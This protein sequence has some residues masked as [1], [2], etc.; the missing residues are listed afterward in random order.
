MPVFFYFLS[1]LVAPVAFFPPIISL[2]LFFAA[3]KRIILLETVKA[4]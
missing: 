3:V 2:H 4:G 1:A